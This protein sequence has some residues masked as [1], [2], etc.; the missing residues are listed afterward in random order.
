MP[1][2]RARSLVREP[3]VCPWSSQLDPTAIRAIARMPPS[4]RVGLAGTGK[5][6]FCLLSRQ[7]RNSI[8]Q[9]KYRERGTNTVMRMRNIFAD[10]R[11]SGKYQGARDAEGVEPPSFEAHTADAAIAEPGPDAE[12]A[13]Q[14][15]WTNALRKQPMRWTL[16]IRGNCSRNVTLRATGTRRQIA[17]HVGEETRPAFTDAAIANFRGFAGRFP[18]GVTSRFIRR[19]RKNRVIPLPPRYCSRSEA[20][21]SMRHTFQRPRR[22][23]GREYSPT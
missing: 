1:A 16:P 20:K 12:K 14:P 4:H 2:P 22:C 11:R 15:S 21:G 7:C 13:V 18:E 9:A 17:R 10:V 5:V 8:G 6:I 23:S 19:C 3:G